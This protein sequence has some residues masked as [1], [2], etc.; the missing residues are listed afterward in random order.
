MRKPSGTEDG[1]NITVQSDAIYW[2]FYK[3]LA[4]NEIDDFI[5]FVDARDFTKTFSLTCPVGKEERTLMHRLIA[6][7]YGAFLETKTFA[8]GPS[9][10]KKIVVRFRQ[11]FKQK[12]TGGRGQK[13][14][15]AEQE[16]VVTG[17]LCK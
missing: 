17:E 16:T 8:S 15:A 3:L 4:T 1:L 5:R 13:R 11:K 2:N 10:D 9:D 14:K 12:G 6:R 7:H